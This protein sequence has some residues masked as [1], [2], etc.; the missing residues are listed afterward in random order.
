MS[1]VLERVSQTSAASS[2]GLRVGRRTASVRNGGLMGHASSIAYMELGSIYRIGILADDLVT[3]ALGPAGDG[4]Q[5][6]LW[7]RRLI[8][9]AAD[10]D[11]GE[12]AHS[13]SLA[14]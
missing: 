9:R 8:G 12:D 10:P 7:R 4:G 5:L 3:A 13:G 1:N 14:I 6:P 11:S 2:E